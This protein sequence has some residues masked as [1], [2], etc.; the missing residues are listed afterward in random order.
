[1]TTTLNKAAINSLPITSKPE[2]ELILCCSRT[3]LN[4]SISER[5]KFLVQQDLDWKYLFNTAAHQGVMP[6][7]YQN[8]YQTCPE[9]VPQDLLSNLRSY[10][11]LNTQRVLLLTAE[12]LKILNILKAN[13]IEAIP[14]KDQL[15]L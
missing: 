12:L 9:Q 1:M 2:I 4:A 10:F 7:L 13:Q 5:I 8:L 11:Q 6:L 3:H 14:F 15:W